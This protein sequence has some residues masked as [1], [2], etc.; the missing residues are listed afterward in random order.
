[1]FAKGVG[2]FKKEKKHPELDRILKISRPKS[3]DDL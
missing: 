2:M 1:L 3:T